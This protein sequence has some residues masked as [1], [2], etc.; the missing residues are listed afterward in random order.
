MLCGLKFIVYQLTSFYFVPRL[1]YFELQE[2]VVQYTQ[3]F[4]PFRSGD[5][6][7][8]QVTWWPQTEMTCSVR[9]DA[10]YG[11]SLCHFSR[12]LSS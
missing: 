8:T 7:T 12:L 3:Q 4:L 5:K 11:Q 2:L 1:N 6:M 9:V 10:A